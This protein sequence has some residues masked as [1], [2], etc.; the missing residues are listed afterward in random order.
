MTSYALSSRF[1]L[2]VTFAKDLLGIVFVSKRN[3]H[4]TAVD[5]DCCFIPAILWGGGLQA[6]LLR[7]WKNTVNSSDVA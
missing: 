2:Q 5:S 4:Y 7:F 3:F 6:G 1:V